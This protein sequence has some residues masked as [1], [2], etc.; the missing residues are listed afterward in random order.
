MR[1]RVRSL[2]ACN[3]EG[4]VR[5]PSPSPPPHPKQE[6]VTG[7][8]LACLVKCVPL[9]SGELVKRAIVVWRAVVR[10][11]LMYGRAEINTGGADTLPTGVALL[12]YASLVAK[13][14][15]NGLKYY[16]VHH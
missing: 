4:V 3:R 11:Q 8:W 1:V 13:T 10:A 6:T 2:S 5:A 9:G 14:L 15:P 12:S 7:T 16:V